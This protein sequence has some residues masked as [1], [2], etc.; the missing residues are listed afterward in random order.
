MQGRR[1]VITGASPDLGQTLALTFAHLGARLYLCARTE[2]KTAATIDLVR[3]HYPTTELWGSPVDM[4]DS[5]DIA[6]FAKRLGTVTNVVDTIIHNASHWIVGSLQTSDDAEI[7][8]AIGSTLTGAAILTK[9]LLPFLARSSCPDIIFVNG[10]PGLPRNSH[11]TAHEAF[12][13]AKAGQAAFADRLRVGLR[14]TGTRVITIYPPNFTSV[15]RLDAAAWS[16]VK[17]N[18]R[19]GYLTSRNVVECILFALRQDR[20]CSIDEIVLG[21]NNLSG[22]GN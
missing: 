5:D 18:V 13:A 3:K 7:V 22:E 1:V 16:Q 8:E 20:I 11:S 6:D 15:S 12:S 10:T 2:E 14:S 19:D 21:N 9:H 17:D 4:C